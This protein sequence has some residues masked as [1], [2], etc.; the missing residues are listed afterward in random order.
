MGL[1]QLTSLGSWWVSSKNDRGSLAY[2]N[3]F[4]FLSLVFC[5]CWDL[6]GVFQSE[7]NRCLSLWG[8]PVLLYRLYF[9]FVGCGER[10]NRIIRDFSI[11]KRCGSF[12]TTSYERKTLLNCQSWPPSMIASLPK[13]RRCCIY[14]V[15]VLNDAPDKTFGGKYKYDTNEWASYVGSF[16][17]TRHKMSIKGSGETHHIRITLRPRISP[18]V[19]KTLS[20]AK[21]LTNL[22]GRMLNFI[23]HYNQQITSHWWH[24]L[25]LLYVPLVA[26]ALDSWLS[27]NFPN[28]SSWPVFQDCPFP[29]PW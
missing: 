16:P 5:G 25:P 2:Q 18:S 7:R 19:R 23:N 22:R 1:A 6:S 17:P 10:A 27:N 13:R 26:L 24:Y 21:N 8:R 11:T 15:I 28:T 29:N 12:V 20:F 14:D 4:S 3:W 9:S